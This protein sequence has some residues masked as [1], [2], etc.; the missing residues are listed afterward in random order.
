MKV[1][2]INR[3]MD[4]HEQDN[5][6]I[7]WANKVKNLKLEDYL[8]KKTEKPVQQNDPLNELLLDISPSAYEVRPGLASHASQP[9]GQ[10]NL[11]ETVQASRP[12]LPRAKQGTKAAYL[13]KPATSVNTYNQVLDLAMSSIKY[14]CLAGARLEGRGRL[15]KR[16][17]ASR[18]VF[19][20][21]WIGGLKTI[22]SSF[23]S[24][25]VVTLRGQSK[26]NVQYTLHRSKT[27]NGA[28]GLKGWIAGR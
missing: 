24:Q 4:R 6:A 13:G 22:E 9:G 10:P 26:P 25:S 8:V 28:F 18:A 12:D 3:H 17:T 16:F 15:T 20:V 5:R 14:T 11:K 1:V 7:F 23:R 21:K 27:R 19:K 2:P